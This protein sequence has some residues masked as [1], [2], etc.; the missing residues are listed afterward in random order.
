MPSSVGEATIYE[1]RLYDRPL[2]R[3]AWTVDEFGEQDVRTVALDVDAIALLPPALTI[4]QSGEVVASWL[5]TRRIPK[6]R[7][8]V[9]KVLAERGLSVADT[10]GIMDV[11][12]GLSTTDAFWVVPAGFEA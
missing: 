9:D 4:D 5:K 12:R 7:A 10:K 8:F 2:L 11:C 3:F 6:N 1:I